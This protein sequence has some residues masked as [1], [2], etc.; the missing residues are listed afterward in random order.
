MRFMRRSSRKTQGEAEHRDSPFLASPGSMPGACEEGPWQREP[1]P[2]CFGCESSSAQAPRSW[3][4][5]AVLIVL[6][7]AACWPLLAAQEQKGGQKEEKSLLLGVVGFYNPR[8]MYLKYQ[9]LADYLSKHTGREW[10]LEISTTYEETVRDLCSGRLALAY[11]GPFTYV[12][13][14]AACDAMPVV[15]LNTG[16]DAYYHSLIMVPA[17]SSLDSIEELR[18][19]RL[20]FG[21]ALSVSSHLMPRWLL[22]EHGLELG[23]D[24]D[25]TFLGHHDRAARAVL[26]G[27]VDACAVR[28][29]IG[30]KFLERGLRILATSEPI[31]NFPLVMPSATDDE[32]IDSILD[33]LVRL[34]A[35]DPEVAQEIAG[36]D[37]ELAGGFVPCGDGEF[38]PIRTIAKELFGAHALTAE[39]AEL[40]RGGEAR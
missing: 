4:L 15:R 27:D 22:R 38:D 24:Y 13:A 8:L 10:K 25:A 9:P 7:L 19:K 1:H 28:D 26:L 11:L 33:A 18:G 29:T 40:T 5:R 32:L 21:A 37:E 20:G 35:N 6:L 12:R 23:R 3:L 31:P 34:P 2:R 16:R 36:W 30:R 14:H 17:R 39:I